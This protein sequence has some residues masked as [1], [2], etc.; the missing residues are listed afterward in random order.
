MEILG[1]GFV[2]DWLMVFL[3]GSNLLEFGSESLKDDLPVV[4][5]VQTKQ[6]DDFRVVIVDFL[7]D[8]KAIISKLKIFSKELTLSFMTLSSRL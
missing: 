3:N 7:N 5:R 2:P 6:L 1:S 4:L 8:L